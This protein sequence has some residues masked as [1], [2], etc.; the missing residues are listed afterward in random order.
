MGPY[1]RSCFAYPIPGE[2][3]EIGLKPRLDMLP[4][5]G[6]EQRARSGQ[7]LVDGTRYGE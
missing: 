3:S 7:W 6:T 5:A 1:F 2:K 4:A